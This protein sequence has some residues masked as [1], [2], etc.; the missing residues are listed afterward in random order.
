MT[1]S[2]KLALVSAAAGLSL[3][4]LP[5][6]AQPGSVTSI[7]LY[8]FNRNGKIDRAVITVDN[9]SQRAWTVRGTG[10]VKVWYGAAQLTISSVFVASSPNANPAKIEIVLD[11]SDS[12]VPRSTAADNL[13]IEYVPAGLGAG[14]D[15]GA[16]ELQAIAKGDTGASDTENDKAGPILPSS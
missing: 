12:N 1:L 6:F 8:D 16:A 13:E 4:A 10:G 2:T 7:N 3:A 9:L 11:E 15:D 14:I 5:A